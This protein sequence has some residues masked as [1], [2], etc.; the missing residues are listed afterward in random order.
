MGP[1]ALVDAESSSE[2][3]VGAPVDVSLDDDDEVDAALIARNWG[4]LTPPLLCLN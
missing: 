1:G 3:S 4:N 2:I